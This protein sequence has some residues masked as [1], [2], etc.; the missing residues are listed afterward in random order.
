MKERA[1]F[2]DGIWQRQF[3]GEVFADLD[4]VNRTVNAWITS[5]HNLS[6]KGDLVALAERV[7]KIGERYTIALQW[8]RLPSLS[9]R[10]A[11]ESEKISEQAA[12]AV[13]PIEMPRNHRLRLG[14]FPMLAHELAHLRLKFTDARD[15]LT[16]LADGHYGP[17]IADILL[18]RH[19][20][21]SL[22]QGISHRAEELAADLIAC[23]IAGPA[24][25]YAVTRFAGGTLM[26]YSPQRR[27]HDYFPPL[28]ERI[29]ACINFVRSLGL[30]VHFESVFWEAR[31]IRISDQLRRDVNEFVAISY[32]MEE[33]S[34]AI[35]PVQ[36]ALGE[37][38]PV[39]VDC[40]QVINALWDAVI[41][42]SG[43]LNE[44]AVLYS[45][46]T[47]HNRTTGG[48]VEIGCLD[49]NAG[50]PA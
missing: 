37:G 48:A 18:Q 3:A 21:D 47:G 15:L 16:G 14:S 40:G 45:V 30:P 11:S 12:M 7:D 13:V 44:F 28:A 49:V 34:N 42:K 5:L 24:Y 33:H 39:E 4:A 36:A 9:V 2:L 22:D 10:L 26:D 43:Y 38:R 8:F 41:R 17:E 6:D 19:S 31:E 27:I 35:G 50:D 29:R 32:G 20:A 25:V 1:R 23:C 46:M